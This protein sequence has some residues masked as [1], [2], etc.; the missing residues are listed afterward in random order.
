MLEYDIVENEY[1]PQLAVSFQYDERTIEQIK[2]LSWET[3]HRTWSEDHDA[4]LIDYTEQSLE[5]FQDQ[6]NVVIPP[7]YTPSE[8]HNGVVRAVVPN[9]YAW[10]FLQDP[11]S[12]IDDLLW[13]ELAYWNDAYKE[14]HQQWI[15]L[16]DT[17]THGAP[18]GLLDKTR[19]LVEASGYEFTV[20]WNG[21]RKGGAVQLDWE[22]PSELREYQRDAINAAK[23]N[24]GGIIALPTG[25]GKTVTAMKLLEE[26]SLEMGRGIVLVHTQELLYQWASEIRDALRVEP[27]VI[28]DGN[29]SEGPV[30]I[31][32]M[33]T[34]MSRGVDELDE[35]Y[36]VA[37][38][39]ECIARSEEITM[40]NGSAKPIENV[41][42]GDRVLSVNSDGGI[43]P[44][45]VTHVWDRGE[46]K[47][48]KV[49]TDD[50]TIRCTP[51]HEVLTDRG[52]VAAENLKANDALYMNTDG[53][54]DT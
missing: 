17:D 27:G 47:I 16:Y 42:V 15:R 18:I 54:H 45:P 36:G 4:W 6:M 26:V 21:D 14:H 30:T 8:D 46:R 20:T 22:F 29:W 48:V 2:L 10:F 52:Y 3:T 25:T 44:Q 12:E 11:S 49:E 43:E 35:S 5:E 1:G 28:G 41:S 53:R 32:V 31:A 23:A 38:F 34:L 24:D 9:E 51:D 7:R 39:D 50:G 19:E 37:V 40:A 13:Q 33:Q